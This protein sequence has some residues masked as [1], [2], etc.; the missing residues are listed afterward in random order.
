MQHVQLQQQVLFGDMVGMLASGVGREQLDWDWDW[1]WALGCW[2]QVWAR[3]S[4][5]AKPGPGPRPKPGPNI[6]APT[7]S[8]SPT[9]DACCSRVC[10]V[11]PV[12]AQDSAD[13]SSN[14]PPHES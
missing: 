10:A 12:S 4:A 3:A 11:D 13:D 6:P 1:A 2:A 8:P 14:G 9:L 7:P 5:Q